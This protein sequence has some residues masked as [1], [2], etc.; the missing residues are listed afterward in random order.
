MTFPTFFYKK[1]KFYLIECWWG[2][3]K[4]KVVFV[5]FRKSKDLARGSVYVSAQYLWGLAFSQSG[6]GLF[7]SVLQLRQFRV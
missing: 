5:A 3:G 4:C 6:M 2:V 7:P 1:A